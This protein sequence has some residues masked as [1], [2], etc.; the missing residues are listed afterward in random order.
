V[1]EVADR[2]TLAVYRPDA[3]FAA[4]ATGSQSS[5]FQ[6]NKPAVQPSATQAEPAPGM[7][8][9][10]EE[11]AVIPALPGSG[12]PNVQLPPLRYAGAA[13]RPVK[14]FDAAVNPDGA[15]PPR[16]LHHQRQ[17]HPNGLEGT[18]TAPARIEEAAA[19]AAEPR[20]D[21]EAAPFATQPP[22]TRAPARQAS[23]PSP[24]VNSTSSSHR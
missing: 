24:S 20:R 16:P 2:A 10:A 9:W 15:A 3:S 23:A 13:P 7:D 6:V 4:A 19:P 14:N 5:A 8:A 22:A 12:G 17:R 18:V 1:A 21:F 11:S